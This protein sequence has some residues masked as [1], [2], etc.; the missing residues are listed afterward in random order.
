MAAAYRIDAIRRVVKL[1]TACERAD[2]KLSGKEGLK[3][4]LSTV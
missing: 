4:S 1:K 2:M 3:E